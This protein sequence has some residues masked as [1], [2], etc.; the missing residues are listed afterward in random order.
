MFMYEQKNASIRRTGAGDGIR[1]MKCY[2]WA[3]EAYFS[4]GAGSIII[5]VAPSEGGQ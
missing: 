5:N 4:G 3:T 2:V 1:R